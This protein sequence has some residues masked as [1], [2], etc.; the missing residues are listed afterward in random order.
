MKH[1]IPFSLNYDKQNVEIADIIIYL[2]CAY[3]NKNTHNVFIK[4]ARCLIDRSRR[5][6]IARFTS[7]GVVNSPYDLNNRHHE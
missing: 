3:T 7:T 6:A 5:D 4:D 1:D 2:R